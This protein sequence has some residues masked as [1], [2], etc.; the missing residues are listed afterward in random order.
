MITR[1]V[2]EWNWKDTALV[3]CIVVCGCIGIVY[4]ETSVGSFLLGSG[5][6]M[7]VFAPQ[8]RRALGMLKAYLFPDNSPSA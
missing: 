7:A 2:V 1:P 4:R 5:F 8:A 6:G 3:V